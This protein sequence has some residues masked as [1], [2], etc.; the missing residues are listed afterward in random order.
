MAWEIHLPKQAL[1]PFEVHGVRWTV[2]NY[3]FWVVLCLKYCLGKKK[4]LKYGLFGTG[5]DP[6]TVDSPPGGGSVRR[7][8]WTG[9]ELMVV[10]LQYGRFVRPHR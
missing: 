3:L 10:N 4:K 8:W 7:S 9:D 5:N 2:D 1:S 6:W